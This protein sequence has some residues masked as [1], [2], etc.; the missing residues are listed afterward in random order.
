[1]QNYRL[2]VIFANRV[3]KPESMDDLNK[4]YYKIS[5]VAELLHI[6][7]STLRF[8]ESK[9]TVIKPKRNAKGT[10]FY[11]PGDIEK[12]SMIHYLVKDRGMHLDAAQQQLKLNPEGVRKHYEAIVRLRNIKD[13]LQGIIGALNSLR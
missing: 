11:T 6:P 13:K 4:K 10:R 9:F 1:M 2:I 5:E 8:W 12:I 3:N 7:N